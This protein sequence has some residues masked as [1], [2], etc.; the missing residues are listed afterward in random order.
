MTHK[1]RCRC[2]RCCRSSCCRCTDN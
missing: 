1:R 2:S